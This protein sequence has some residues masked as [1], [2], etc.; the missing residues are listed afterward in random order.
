VKLVHKEGEIIRR[1][2]GINEKGELIVEDEHG[3]KEAV[4]SGEVSVRGLYGYT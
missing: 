2:L 3:V 1:A 4:L